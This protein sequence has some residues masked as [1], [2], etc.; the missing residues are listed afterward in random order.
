MNIDI[1]TGILSGSLG[2]V[3]L[4]AIIDVFSKDREFRKELIK[5]TYLRN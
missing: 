4:T 3:L 2:T 5:A 1:I